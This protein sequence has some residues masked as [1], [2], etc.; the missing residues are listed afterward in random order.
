MVFCS[1]VCV[2]GMRHVSSLIFSQTLER[3]GRN[4][5]K[6]TDIRHS[7][8]ALLELKTCLEEKN[9]IVLKCEE[10]R[11]EGKLHYRKEKKSMPHYETDCTC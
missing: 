9:L 2:D 6:K 10:E 1:G 5:V 8:Q 4:S 7:S 3:E 11:K